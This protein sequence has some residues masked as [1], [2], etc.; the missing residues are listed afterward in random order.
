MPDVP[1]PP[2]KFLDTDS[3][4]W[5]GFDE[6]PGVSFKVLKRHAPGNG[7]TML[8]RF[9]PDSAY[10]AHRHV[11]GEEYLVLTGELIDG[12]TTY[13]A[14]TYVYHP[15]GSVHRPRS[16]TGATLLVF[17]PGGIDVVG[18]VGRADG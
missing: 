14:G 6:A 13:G 12:A 2:S 15:P 3:M 5:R 9:G 18:S 11:D 4:P 7:A 1:L 17:V 10:P 8:L 16:E